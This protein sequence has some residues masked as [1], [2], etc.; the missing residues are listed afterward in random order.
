[1]PIPHQSNESNANIYVRNTADA[2][3]R[4][5][6]VQTPEDLKPNTFFIAYDIEKHFPNASRKHCRAAMKQI[7]EEEGNSKERI[8]VLMA[9]EEYVRESS[10]QLTTVAFTT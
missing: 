5:E 4:I 7:L 6:Q 9:L 10:S 3:H 2:V 8:N 1:M